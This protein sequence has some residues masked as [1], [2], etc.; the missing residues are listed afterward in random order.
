MLFRQVG[1]PRRDPARM[2]LALAHSHAVVWVRC[3]R[4]SRWARLGQLLAFARATSDTAL[5]ATIWDVAVRPCEEK[6]SFEM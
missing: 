4:G 1:F 2:R 3:T 6:S 5:S